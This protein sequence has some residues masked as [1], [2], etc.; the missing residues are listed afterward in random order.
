MAVGPARE[1][2]G[3]TGRVNVTHSPAF[4]PVKP[5]FN[6]PGSKRMLAPWIISHFPA[7]DTYIEPFAGSASVFFA[8]PPSR[9]EHLN[10]LNGRIV[11]L[12]R[13]LREQGPAV[14]A[15]LAL[16]PYAREEF[17]QAIAEQDHADDTEFARRFIIQHQ[18]SISGN[19]GAQYASGWKHNGPRT[20]HGGAIA[21]WLELPERALRVCER[22]R[23]AFIECQPAEQLIGRYN[24]PGTLLYVDPPY[25]RAVRTSAGR[26][27]EKDMLDDSSHERLL[28]LLRAH[29]GPVVLSG[30]DCAL[31]NDLLPDWHQR[32]APAI[33]QQ[34]SVRREVL[35]INR[36]PPAAA[37]VDLWSET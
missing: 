36:Q 4:T 16:T 22:L 23:E 11:R 35:W 29:T 32:T 10:D 27:Y 14:A 13:V 2:H 19:S 37:P 20:P 9:S 24:H 7:H 30:Y 1:V 25:P 3:P 18:M 8:K 15:A 5:P 33:S 12:F 6:Y 28:T 34:G 21:Q 31:Y 17:T 26:L